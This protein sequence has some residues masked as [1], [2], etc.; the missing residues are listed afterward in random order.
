V[1]AAVA[2]WVE[3]ER[4]REEILAAIDEA[5]ASLARGDGL[6]IAKS[7]MRE[8]ADDVKRR[9]APGYARRKKRA[10][11][12]HG[13]S[14]RARTD[15]DSIW[16]HIVIEGGSESVANGTVDLIADRFC[17]CLTGPDWVALAMTCGAVC[18]AFRS[19]ITSFFTAILELVWS[20][21]GY[22]MVTRT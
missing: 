12:A 10:R 2:L 7:S 15:L 11:R 18:A 16:Y 6:I 22:L 5:E 20:F 13:V 8:L 1:Q 3:R 17:F 21:T 9:A 14:S 19:A 4:R